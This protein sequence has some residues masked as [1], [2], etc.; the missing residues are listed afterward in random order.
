MKSLSLKVGLKTDPIDYRYS[1]EWLF[2]LLAE[3][4]IGDIQLGSFVEIYHL[5]DDFFLWLRQ[6]AAGYDISITSMFTSHRELGGFFR[7]EPGWM[8]VT[9]K[10]YRRLIDIGALLGTSSVGSNAGAAL[11]DRMDTKDK[12]VRL[13]MQ[14]MKGLMEYACERGITTLCLE[15]MSSLAEPP[16]LPEEIENMLRELNEHHSRHPDTTARFGLC[17]DIA[18]G[19]ADRNGVVRSNGQQLLEASLPYLH[20]VHLKNTDSLFRETFAFS[21]EERSYGTIQVKE[22]TDLL[23]RRHDEIPVHEIVGYLEFDGLK[24]GRDYTD[25]LLG[26]ALRESLRYLKDVFTADTY[27]KSESGDLPVGTVSAARTDTRT[28]NRSDSRAVKI[29]PSIMCADLCHLEDEIRELERLEVD[30]LHFD[31]MDAHFTPNM[32][33]GLELIRRLRGLTDLPFDVHLMVEDNELFIEWLADIGVQQVSVHAESARHLDRTLDVIRRGGMAAG[34]ALNPA[35]PLSVLDYV[36]A[37]MDFLMLMTVNPGFAG[38]KLV[39]SALG[40]IRDARVR[41]ESRGIDLPIEVDGNVSFSNVPRMV[42]A[43]ADV[44]VVGTSSL[45]HSGRSLQENMHDL[46]SAIS[47]GAAGAPW[48]R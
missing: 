12:G 18:H 14:H 17:F 35:T 3:E 30:F 15:P 40:K 42:A 20:E 7:D 1:F 29:S 4:G 48:D 46:R 10:N 28:D 33:L 13:Y 37:G 24:K 31:L 27:E 47:T 38:Q 22:F 23:M 2:R 6:K 21:R 34:V 39:P 16:T 36:A 26:D 32:P 41:L 9:Q 8:E 5:P 44:L 45:F 43:G 11:R 19:Y 25:H